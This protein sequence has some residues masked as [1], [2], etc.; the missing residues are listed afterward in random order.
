MK[1]FW[2]FT[3]L[4]LVVVFP[5]MLLTV[6]L[7]FKRSMLV[8]FT[9]VWMI[10][11]VSI[12]ILAYGVGRLGSLSDFLW[13]F[14][15]GV[16]LPVISFIYLNKNIRL[17]IKSLVKK[18]AKVADGDLDQNL[19]NEEINRKDEIGEIAEALNQILISQNYL[20]RE[21]Q[22]GAKGLASATQQLSSTSEQLSQGANE[23][24]S[25]VE[26]V[27]STMEEIAANIENNSNN[28]NKT[29]ERAKEASNGIFQVKNAAGESLKSVHDI[30]EKIG[31]IN[32]I[33]FQTNIL[34][35][36]AAVEAARAGDQGK[37]FAVVATEVRKLAEKSKV[38]ADEII[39]LAERSVRVTDEAGNF[40][41][42]IIP[43]IEETSQLV[44]EI[45]SASNEQRSGAMQVNNAV[46]QLNNVTQQNA[47]SAELLASSAEELAA[48]SESL[49]EQ[50]STFKL[51]K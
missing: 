13:A 50:I 35:L 21:I 47:A 39:H 7:I 14:P 42:S 19:E 17:V 29:E 24:A 37:G 28:A 22:K 3:F 46:Q 8:N 9:V 4:V 15:I 5:A 16:I 32:D 43:A 18:L 48:Q 25:S 41:N 27:S 40:M 38:A 10:N 51:K 1:D 31:I 33:A 45:A 30:A 11:Q 6:K 12:V 44:L 2:I 36:N 20:I 34:A 49:L 26:E 23:Q